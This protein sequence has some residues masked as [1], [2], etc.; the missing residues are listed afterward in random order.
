MTPDFKNARE[1]SPDEKPKD[2]W[3]LRFVWKEVQK[4]VD[5]IISWIDELE[6][7]LILLINYSES[8]ENE[9][10]LKDLIKRFNITINNWELEWGDKLEYKEDFTKIIQQIPWIENIKLNII[11]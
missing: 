8:W 7:I 2:I 3:K 5:N 6:N 11:K 1:L 10:Y 4:N 9:D